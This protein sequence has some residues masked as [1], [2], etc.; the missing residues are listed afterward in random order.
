MSADRG[1]N[2]WRNRRVWRNW[3]SWEPGPFRSLGPFGN[4]GRRGAL[5]FALHAGLIEDDDIHAPVLLPALLGRLSSTGAVS[6]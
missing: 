5:R 6:A 4:R 2:A 1:P 3:R